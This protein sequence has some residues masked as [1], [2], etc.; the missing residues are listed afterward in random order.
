MSL[1]GANPPLAK[2][3]DDFEA[4]AAVYTGLAGVPERPAPIIICPGHVFTGLGRLDRPATCLGP[5]QICHTGESG[6][7]VSTS[8]ATKN[9]LAAD[10]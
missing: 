1:S 2:I 7:E 9:T 4:Y 3:S 10:T 5:N 8:I 6:D